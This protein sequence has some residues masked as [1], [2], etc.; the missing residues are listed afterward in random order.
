[1]PS[2]Y[3]CILD[4]SRT[5]VYSICPCSQIFRKGKG[6]R[7]SHWICVSKQ[8]ISIRIRGWA[9]LTAVCA[10]CP[11]FNS[12]AAAKPSIQSSMDC[13]RTELHP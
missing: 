7:M 5:F 9:M 11:L 12:F 8:V 4:L 2:T 3:F 6:E 1:M 13:S 10:Q